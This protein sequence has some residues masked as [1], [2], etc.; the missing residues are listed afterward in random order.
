[1][2]LGRLGVSSKENTAQA[3]PGVATFPPRQDQLDGG[4]ASMLV[5]SSGTALFGIPQ[6]AVHICISHSNMVITTF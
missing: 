4:T 6:H 5:P 1:M 3:P 2:N